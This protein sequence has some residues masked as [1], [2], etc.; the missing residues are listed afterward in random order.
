MIEVSPAEFEE[1]GRIA[2]SLGFLSVASAPLV[3]SSYHADRQ[4]DLGRLRER[5]VRPA[6]PAPGGDHAEG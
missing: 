6:S 2:E 3:R 1:L 4:V 5:Q